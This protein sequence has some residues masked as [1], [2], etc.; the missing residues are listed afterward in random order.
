MTDVA[1]TVFL[2]DVDNTLLDNDRVQADLGQHLA[3]CYGDEARDRYWEIFENLRSELG[4]SDY[5]GALEL[6]RI[7]AMHHPKV[8]R[9]ANWLVDYPFQERLYPN[10]I[11]VVRAAQRAGVTA[12]LSDGDAVFQPRKVERSGLWP[13]FGD[14]VLIYVHKELELEDV[15]YHFPARHYVMIDD[16]LRILDAIKRAWGD[17]VT[18]VFPRQGHYATDAAIL[19]EF[20]PADV[21]VDRIGDLLEHDLAALARR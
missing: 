19:A 3:L 21:T 4:Y 18:T 20:P 16:K 11:D 14:N 12:I 17:R 6:Y 10:A 9:V 13:V 8:L 5:L 1:D 2:F 7:E 15:E